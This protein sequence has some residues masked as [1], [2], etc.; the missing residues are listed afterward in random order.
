MAMEKISEALKLVD[1]KKES[2]R[3]AF[4]ELESHSASLATFPVSWPDLDS[5]FS[6]I[7]SSLIS[8]FQ[9]LKSHQPIASTTQPTPAPQSDLKSKPVRGS[10]SRGNGIV[11]PELK[12]LCEKMD[13][14]GLRKY[15]NNRH[16]ELNSI[17]QDLSEAF[18][19]AS[20]PA[21]MVLAAM[22][23]FYPVDVNEQPKRKGDRDFD[24]MD[25]RRTCVLLL[26]E[27]MNSVGNEGICGY[28]KEKAKNLAMEWKRK[29]SRKGAHSLE[30]LGFLTLV[31]T[32]DLK[33][34][35]DADEITELFV[36][37][38]R[39]REAT[40]LCRMFIMPDKIPDII[41]K[42]IEAK[43]QLWAVKFICEFA[44][45]EKFP[46]VP[47][48]KAYVNDA[49][50]SAKNIRNKGNHSR[51]AVNEAMSKEIDALETVMKYIKDYKLESEY[52]PR[53][54]KNRIEEI[55][56]NNNGKKRPAADMAN[57]HQQ[58]NR[59]PKGQQSSGSKR[60][61]NTASPN[62]T[63]VQT[64]EASIRSTMTPYQPTHLPTAGL[65]LDKNTMYVGSSVRSYGL[66]GSS[67]YNNT[68]YTASS[69]VTPYMTLNP[70]VSG[71]PGSNPN[72]AQ[73]SGNQDVASYLG[74][75]P[76]VD[77]QGNSLVGV[78]TTAG[79]TVV[80]PAQPSPKSSNTYFPQPPLP[81]AYYSTATAY[82][83]GYSVPPQYHP[84]YYPQ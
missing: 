73:H 25:L 7:Q 12:S 31:A 81:S 23:G 66:A 32:Y 77:S 17:K 63:T 50:Q 45:A 62:P 39:F 56:S 68:P 38:A 26:E 64:H 59:K 28:V 75:T 78:Y 80:H 48:L 83:G 53:V 60:F 4:L 30:V 51:Q 69:A 20:D 74:S 8:Q 24:V 3:K 84:Q 14:I 13:G 61:G 46:P 47:L 58:L 34:E 36:E 44:L 29:V 10:S 55:K 11:R 22:E 57:G 41:Q 16:K 18:K 35:F 42:L 72:L 21:L 49:K 6:S 76:S 65:M 71:F 52:P 67:D 79:A 9:L 2:L 54:L 40:N 15:I 82:G 1:A 19:F 37:A 70:D 5:H 43:K 33:S 27:L